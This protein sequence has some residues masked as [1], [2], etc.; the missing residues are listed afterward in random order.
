MSSNLKHTMAF[1]VMIASLA[2]SVGVCFAAE[3]VS[4]RLKFA[5]VR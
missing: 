5:E 2:L 1:S 4:F 3:K